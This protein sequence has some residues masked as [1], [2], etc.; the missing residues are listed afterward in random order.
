MSRMKWIGGLIGLALLACGTEKVCAQVDINE[1]CTFAATI[2]IQNTNSTYNTNTTGFSTPSP[3]MLKFATKDL[4]ALAAKGEFHNGLWSSNSVPSGAKLMKFGTSQ[5]ALDFFVTDSKN[6][7]LFDCS[8]LIF[9]GSFDDIMAYSNSGTDNNTTAGS[10]TDNG[11]IELDIY[12]LDAGGTTDLQLFGSFVNTIKTSAANKN[13]GTIN[14]S[15]SFTVKALGGEGAIGN[16]DVPNCAVSGSFSAK[17][18][19][20][21]F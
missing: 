12:D 8:D 3:T 4:L 14:N 11:F 17:G 2:L 1:T 13:T 16:N 7:T 5:F 20:Q 21:T 10:E 18:T 19:Q 15:Q 9:P 6:N